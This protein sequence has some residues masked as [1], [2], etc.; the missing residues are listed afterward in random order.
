YSVQVQANPAGL[1]C[2]VSSGAGVMPAGGISNVTVTCASTR[3]TIGG[4]ISGL[5]TD[6]LVLLN[7]GSDSTTLNNG[8]TSFA[9]PTAVAYGASYDITVGTQ[10]YGVNL[11]CTPSNNTSIA[12]A[13]VTDVAITCAAVTP[14]QTLL[15]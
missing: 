15:A 2:T 6:G 3:Y 9:M 14:T 11:A 8:A 12:T 4:S 5:T 7:N 1:A 10:P 13:D